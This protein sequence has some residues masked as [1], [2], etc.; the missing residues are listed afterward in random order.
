MHQ[1]S[2][3]RNGHRL[4][5]IL[6]IA[7]WVLLVIISVT[8]DTSFRAAQDT[9]A[10]VS[11]AC[12]DL[13]DLCLTESHRDLLHLACPVT[14]DACAAP[15]I[16]NYDCRDTRSEC[17]RIA[18]AERCDFRPLTFWRD[19][20]VSCRICRPRPG[21]EQL[22]FE[23]AA[24]SDK[25][26]GRDEDHASPID[27]GCRDT[28]G[29]CGARAA[30]G[31]CRNPASRAQM[32]VD[33]ARSC[34]T[35]Q[36]RQDGA[37]GGQSV[38]YESD[39]EVALDKPWD[40]RAAQQV[41][42][43]MDARRACP[44]W[45]SVGECEREPEAMRKLCAASCSFCEPTKA[46]LTRPKLP[47]IACEPGR[48]DRH[49]GCDEWAAAGECTLGRRLM[50]AFCPCACRQ[51]G[52]LAL[53]ERVLAGVE[54]SGAASSSNRSRSSSS[55]SGSTCTDVHERCEGWA[56]IGLCSV[57]PIPMRR[58]CP[59]AC[60]RC[61]G[62]RSEAER[63]KLGNLET[64]QAE[65][66]KLGNLSLETEQ[67]QASTEDEADSSGRVPPQLH[68]RL[69]EWCR[70][71]TLGRP[72]RPRS[73]SDGLADLDRPSEDGHA[74]DSSTVRR[75]TPL[76]TVP[77]LRRVALHDVRLSAGTEFHA[78]QQLNAEYLLSLPPDRLLWS[79]RHVAG[80]AH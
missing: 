27:G 54:R 44:F 16:L 9:C 20:P 17:G 2:S 37:P 73:R 26:P 4:T 42:T 67:P 22:V 39:E 19:C 47:R 36:R 41:P 61:Q 46:Q 45:L 79:F 50:H 8:F 59:S 51:P 40:A 25:E 38:G 65:P 53:A 30:A 21:Q 28:S 77:L 23:V 43:C 69:G 15:P 56:L 70:A 58:L 6:G 35:C 52:V 71:H 55:N 57:M 7:L 14:C 5:A 33:C 32:V 74:A 48:T 75:V 31:Q 63:S 66:S 64:E 10:D 72:P 34:G 49:D 12:I 24:P 11:P 18:H 80:D 78:A 13:R 76:S 60:K 68:R 1:N 62:G 3:M 29:D